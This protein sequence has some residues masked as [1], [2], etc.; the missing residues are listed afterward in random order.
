MSAG[1]VLP[2]RARELEEMLRRLHAGASAP[3]DCAAESHVMAAE[4]GFYEMLVSQQL[5]GGGLDLAQF[6]AVVAQLARGCPPSALCLASLAIGTARAAALGVHGEVRATIAAAGGGSAERVA[7]GWRISGSFGSC[8]GVRA[9]THLLGAASSAD[10]AAIEFLAPL[11]AITIGGEHRPACGAEVTIEDVAVADAHAAALEPQDALAAIASV[12]L[13]AVF[14]GAA[15][16]IAELHVE[17]VRA[18]PAAAP[19][20]DHQRWMGHAIGRASTAGTLLGQAAVTFAQPGGEL[21]LG[22]IAHRTIGFSWSVAQESLRSAPRDDSTLGDEL[23]RLAGELLALRAGGA[24]SAEDALSRALAREH[25]AT[26][27]AV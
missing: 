23:A 22:S 5:G 7:G 9:A 4:S 24:A 11:E 20:P 1:E 15:A 26:A 14:A 18:S 6:V 10:G 27:A 13:A 8:A 3:D 21:R 2:A 25:L 17:L 12:A 16:R 19:D